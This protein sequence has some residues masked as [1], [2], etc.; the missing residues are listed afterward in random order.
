M[1]RLASAAERFIIRR[2]TRTIF[3][4][5]YDARTAQTCRFAGPRQ[6][7]AVIYNG[8]AL[9]ALPIPALSSAKHIGFIGRLEYQKDPMLFVEVM[10]QL[11]DYTA[12]MVGGGAMEATVRA[13]I[14]R[15]GVM[16]RVQML[17]TLS[18]D[19]TLQVLPRLSAIVMTSRWEGLPLVPLEAM[20]Y[21]VPVVAV[22]VGGVSEII[23]HGMHGMLV[24]SR[25]ASAL[26]QA[27]RTV[28]EEWAVREPIIQQA[29]ARVQSLFGV[30]QMAAS[31]R[32]VYEE[33]ALEAR[34][35][36]TALPEKPGQTFHDSAS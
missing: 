4:S 6:K 1:R 2:A 32:Q 30:D 26:A 8:I 22:E 10:A 35:R 15:R 31:L 17:G 13:E 14:Q 27:V 33:V 5:H 34:S 29:R 20:W 12:I 9:S 16:D 25:S 11:P 18:Q 24:Q 23:E 28:T 19:D 7:T 3:V 21:G 36:S